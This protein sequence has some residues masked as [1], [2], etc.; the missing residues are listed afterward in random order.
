MRDGTP[1]E[2]PAAGEGELKVS[3]HALE[4]RPD[5][6]EWIVG[7]QG[8]EQV[9][10]L[11]EIGMTAVRL[12]AAGNTVEGTRRTLRDRTGRDID[13]LAFA[14]RLAAAGLVSLIGE[15][16]FPATVPAV[17]FP[18][19]RPQHVRWVMNP[20]LQGFVLLVPVV[21]L[22]AALSRPSVLPSY[23]DL[24]WTEY[25]TFTVLVQ[26]AVASS[27][28]AL[29][30]MA[31]LV[32]AR[33]AGVPG[34]IRLGTRLQ[35]L[36]AQTEVS[37]VWLRSRRERLTVYL[38]GLALDG[39]V[40][41]GCL[42][43]RRLGVEWVLLPVITMTLVTSLAG[44]CLVFM[45]TDLYFVIQ[46]LTGCRDLYRDTG[47]YLRHVVER[48]CGR[49]SRNPLRSL[50]AA[51]RRFLRTYALGTAAGTAICVFVGLRILVEVTWPLMHRS[52]VH[53]LGPAGPWVR[54]DALTG[55]LVVAGLQ[56]L[57]ARLWWKRHAGRVG[58]AVR[59]V[60]E[61]LSRG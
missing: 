42:L 28:I 43:A 40:W 18:R 61:R 59:T 57:W 21:G 56:V 54:L 60:L 12:L 17:S 48:A 19:L 52:L 36:V 2:K 8:G 53:L 16:R 14:E 45:R 3:F 6:N 29:H 32:T 33:A 4:C 55:M 9:I 5:R 22:L 38:S 10:A 27:L 13:V 41:G 30:E 15:R 37:G 20:V 25:G 24:L 31:H 44:Q 26:C 51:E 50:P 46:D 23:G 58:R 7:A 34:R 49:P 47:R 35:F 1:A 11:P 39:V